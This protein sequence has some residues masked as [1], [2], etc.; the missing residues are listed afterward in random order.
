MDWFIFFYNWSFI[1]M[2]FMHYTILLLV[3]L[4]ELFLPNT[5]FIYTT[6][7]I[8][9]LNTLFNNFSVLATGYHY[10]FDLTSRL[11]FND[12]FVNLFNFFWT[13]FT[14]LPSFFFLIFFQ[15]M[16]LKHVFKTNYYV[17]IVLLVY[18][19]YNIELF[20]FVILNYQFETISTNYSS[21]NLLLTNSL[22][23]YHPFIF[24]ISVIL[25]FNILFSILSSL[26]LNYRCFLLN[27]INIDT[28]TNVKLVLIFNIFALF[29][30]SWWAL[31]E[32]TWGGWWN[33][34]PS[35]VLGLLFSLF[36]LF[37]I[38]TNSNGFYYILLSF[39]RVSMYVLI[40]VITYLFIQLNFD[41]V[42]HNFGSKFFFFFNNN[43]FFLEFLIILTLYWFCMYFKTQLS[44][45][46]NILSVKNLK[47]TYYKS[48]TLQHHGLVLLIYVLVILVFNSIVPLLNYF[49][50]T[51]LKINSFNF[52]INNTYFVFIFTVLLISPFYTTA[53]PENYLITFFL[54]LN[55]MSYSTVIL[56][57]IKQVNNVISILHLLLVTFLVVNMSSY[58]L[59][60]IY[61]V[62]ANPCDD[63]IGTDYSMFKLSTITQ[64]NG[65]LVENVCNYNSQIYNNLTSW[66]VFYHSNSQS[67]NTFNLLFDNNCF[68]NYYNLLDNYK[69]LYLFIETNE[70]NNLIEL[71]ILLMIWFTS[72]LVT[73][74]PQSTHF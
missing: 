20:D 51:Y 38:H 44:F 31:Q 57:T 60:F 9:S 6:I 63:V 37:I 10:L 56:N 69:S 5:H 70:L 73:Y 4:L 29:L 15:L 36:V 46:E 22:N 55:S 41:L 19:L 34:D 74:K 58:S 68:Y 18:W 3:Y 13:S 28:K 16:L 53:K 42:S 25:L 59:T 8:I 11:D 67:L 17:I 72:K 24:Y 7:L 14:Y 32:G 12:S 52:L 49:I 26:L 27:H 47:F 65:F 43:L 64:C 40:T 66:N 50:W 71:C 45:V 62:V 35:E 33:W 30:G 48:F 1:T 21:I 61:W 23:K 2:I 54:G 39:Y